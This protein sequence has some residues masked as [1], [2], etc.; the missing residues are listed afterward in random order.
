MN[1]T[2]NFSEI[3]AIDLNSTQ[4][5]PFNLDDPLEQEVEIKVQNGF[6]A[7]VCTYRNR[8]DGW[9]AFLFLNF[10]VFYLVRLF[11]SFFVFFHS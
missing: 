2:F 3:E 8:P 4:V 10:M 11:V 9:I 1:G 7:P 6:I 5:G